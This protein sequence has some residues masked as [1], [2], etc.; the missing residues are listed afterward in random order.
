VTKTMRTFA[1]ALCGAVLAVFMT[2]LSAS[3]QMSKLSPGDQKVV[4]ALFEAQSKPKS[5]APLLT[6]DQIA[7][8]KTPQGWSAVFRDLK[9]KGFLT[10][11]S[12]GQIVA[13]YDRRHPELAKVASKTAK[14]EKPAR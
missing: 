3:A 11:K 10:Q 14:T 1:I 6:R 4:Q 9:G 13:D 7:A 12:L 5:G 2:Q 8:M